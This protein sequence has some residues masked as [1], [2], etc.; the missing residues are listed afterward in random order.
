MIKSLLHQEHSASVSCI[1]NAGAT[2]AFADVDINT[3]NISAD[4]ISAVLTTQTKAIITVHLA[5][6]P[7]DMDPILALA[8]KHSIK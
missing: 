2:P 5:G 3:G 7:C 4:T 1:I 8:K 6:W